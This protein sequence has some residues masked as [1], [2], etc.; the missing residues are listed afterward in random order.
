MSLCPSLKV[1]VAIEL[2]GDL[3]GETPRKTEE[4][5]LRLSFAA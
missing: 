4:I 3:A 1:P 2:M 5:L